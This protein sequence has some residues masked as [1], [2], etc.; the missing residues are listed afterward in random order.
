MEI[1]SLVVT[2]ISSV[3]QFGQQNRCLRSND[4]CDHA[5]LGSSPTCPH[6]LLLNYVQHSQ[7]L[8]D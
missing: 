2:D 7:T 1:A 8:A 3:M 5:P 6:F 4:L